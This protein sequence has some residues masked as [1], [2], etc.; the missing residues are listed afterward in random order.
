MLTVLDGGQPDRLPVTTHHLMP[1]FLDTYID[2]ISEAD[3][4]QRF[5]LDA[6]RWAYDLKP[7][8]GR[9]EY[10]LFQQEGYSPCGPK[11]GVQTGRGE[12]GN[13]RAVSG[14]ADAEHLPEAQWIVS[15]E[16]RIESEEVPGEPDATRYNMVT[17]GGTLSMV[18]KRGPQTDWVMERPIKEKSQIELL[19]RYAPWGG[20][21]TEA[22]HRQARALGDTGI[23]RGAVP[24][25]Q[26][27]G[28]PGCWQDAVELFGIQELIMETLDDP[29]WVREFLDILRD[30]KLAAVTSMEGAPLDLIELGGGSASS[31]V[32]SPKIFEEF[33]APCDQALI[34]EAHGVGLRVVYHTCGGMMPLL[35][36]IADMGP[37]AM[38]TFTPPALGGDTDLREAKRR[39]GGRVCMIGG[40]D[41]HSFFVGCSPEETREA[42]RRCFQE[43]GGEGGYILAPSDHFFDAELELLE[44]F[45]D[46]ART[47]LYET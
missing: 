8:E 6:V 46:E 25:F 10:R 40:F 2:G 47:C 7:D 19:A 44:T 30:R 34:E 11:E 28:Q 21:D 35:E 37:D 42:V 23:L 29:L 32:I 45:A 5:G 12:S 36:M 18:L 43:A 33:V 20:C 41:Q 16:W 13:G 15:H 1:Y 3:F 14:E 26:I 9:G 4:F 24:G 38:E 17:P 31:T 27:Y 39:I 22:I